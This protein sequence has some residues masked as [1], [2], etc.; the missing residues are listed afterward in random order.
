MLGFFAAGQLTFKSLADLLVILR[1]RARSRL[2][3]V[4]SDGSRT[5]SWRHTIG[6]FAA[7]LLHVPQAPIFHSDCL[8]RIPGTSRR[9]LVATE[10]RCSHHFDSFAPAPASYLTRYTASERTCY[11]LPLGSRR[12]HTGAAALRSE[13][14]TGHDVQN[15]MG[16]CHLGCIH[17]LRCDV[18]D[19]CV[20]TAFL[21]A[22]RLQVWPYI[23]LSVCL[24]VW[25]LSG[26]GSLLS[27]QTGLHYCT[28]Y[29]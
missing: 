2:C 27:D 10:A 29:I 6:G 21:S 3:Q 16:M 19:V 9:S 8:Y 28:L 24:D 23:Y 12:Q 1:R 4:A 13:K 22:S 25:H 7:V 20:M 5:E 26:A 15:I 18:L 11:A 14:S 17:S